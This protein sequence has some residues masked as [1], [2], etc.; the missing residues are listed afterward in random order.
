MYRAWLNFSPGFAGI[1]V[2]ASIG[3]LSIAPALKSGVAI[4]EVPN[5]VNPISSN[6]SDTGTMPPSIYWVYTIIM[7]RELRIHEQISAIFELYFRNSVSWNM[8][9]MPFLYS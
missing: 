2:R 7:P 5:R 3:G 9:G 1:I 4:A 6:A 8:R